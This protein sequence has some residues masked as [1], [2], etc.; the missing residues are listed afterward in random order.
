MQLYRRVTA[1]KTTATK[2]PV[3]RGDVEMFYAGAHYDAVA[4]EFHLIHYLQPALFL[5]EEKAIC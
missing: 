1:N 3:M 4:T 5:K 2:V